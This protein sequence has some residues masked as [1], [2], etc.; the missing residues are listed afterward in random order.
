MID[1]VAGALVRPIP[2]PMQHHLPG[3]RQ[4]A[5]ARAIPVEAQVEPDGERHQSAGDH[6]L[7]AARTASLVPSTEVTPTMIATGSSRTPVES[8]P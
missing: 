4:V 1:S 6:Q 3:D 7:R 8:G 5:R 2:A